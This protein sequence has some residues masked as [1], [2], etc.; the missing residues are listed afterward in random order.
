MQILF[1]LEYHG[2]LDI[3]VTNETN[4]YLI[5]SSFFTDVIYDIIQR[6]SSLIEGAPE[7]IIV[8]QTEPNENRI[9]IQR[10]G[11]NCTFEILE[12]DDNF[13][14]DEID[15]GVSVFFTHIDLMDLAR[16]FLIEINKLLDLGKA[17]YHR[18]WSYEFPE[19]AYKRY[20]KAWHLLKQKQ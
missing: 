10:D 13:N 6:I 15:K 8:I 17:E 3:K 11:L 9:R 16:K 2:W 20:I 14:T 5:P 18:R 12:F 4:E 19:E 1:N 7:V